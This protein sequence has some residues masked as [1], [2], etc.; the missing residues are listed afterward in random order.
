MKSLIVLLLFAGLFNMSQALAQCASGIPEAGNPQCLPPD[1]IN[2]PYYQGSRGQQGTASAQHES[3]QQTAA[4]P[5]WYSAIAYD[6]HSGL[7]WAVD[8]RSS[9]KAQKIALEY[10]AKRGGT[11]CRILHES[12][13]S[14][15]S[16]LVVDSANKIYPG[17]NVSPA[18][19]EDT[20]MSK[21]SN[22]SI[23]G[24]CQLIM[25]S[26]CSGLNYEGP[27]NQ[28]AAQATISDMAALSEKMEHRDYWGA[29]VVDDK[30]HSYSSFGFASEKAGEDYALNQSPASKVIATFKNTC[31]GSARSS[32]G[33]SLIQL[34]KDDDPAR[35][36]SEALAQCSKKY[37]ACRSWVRCSGRRYAQPNPI[38]DDKAADLI[39]K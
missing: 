38:A 14:G 21:C 18:S 12:D 15:C 28:A 2:S 30:A 13:G 19:A 26:V 33:G 16:S 10:C 34:A 27:V 37:G 20:A 32:D 8:Q 7:S 1:D 5:I 31:L 6:D 3:L 9:R 25:L 24:H 4:N 23:G 29:E 11:A 22:E 36:K 35:A 17:D 39:P